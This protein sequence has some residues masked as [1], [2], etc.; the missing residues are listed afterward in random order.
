VTPRPIFLLSLPRSGSTLVQRV[1]A[2][3]D[4]IS[5]TPEPWLLLPQM[6]AMREGGAFAEYGHVPASRAVREFADNLPGGREAYDDEL[7]RFVLSLYGRAATSGA[8]FFLDKTPRYHFIVDDL[9]A[10]F[11][12]A[13]L[14]FLWRNPLAIVASIV[15]TWG[16]GRW[17]VERWRV[18]LF[19]G[20]AHLTEA[21]PRLAHRSISVRYEDLVSDPDEAW[22]PIFR[23][24]DL[25]FDG[26]VLETFADVAATAR[27]GDPTGSVAYDTLTTEP[28]T[29]WRAVVSNPVRRNWCRRYLEWIG[30]ERLGMMGYDLGEILADLE[31]I[32]VGARRTGSDVARSIYTAADRAGRQAAAKILWRKR[33]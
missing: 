18:D 29:K 13:Y 8:R 3:S 9:A 1:L 16:R 21:F 32:N 20:I 27:M 30:A 5:T 25:P 14:V 28:L 2:S 23:Y 17:D 19:D 33:R 11:P 6:Y 22:R 31:S 24:L 7:R 12:D 4:A 26:K 10:L 15:E